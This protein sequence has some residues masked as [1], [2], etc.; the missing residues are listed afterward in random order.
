MSLMMGVLWSCYK[1]RCLAD[2]SF[3]EIWTCTCFTVLYL[4]YIIVIHANSS[5]NAKC[6]AK[7]TEGDI[8][9]YYNKQ[10]LYEHRPS[11]T[12]FRVT[13]L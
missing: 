4:G 12:R 2:E 9:P 5:V 11:E 10:V 13:A 3:I 1:D 8:T 6:R 7:P